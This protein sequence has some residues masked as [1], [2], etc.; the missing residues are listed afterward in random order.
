MTEPRARVD[1][2]EDK[3]NG[4]LRIST[5]VDVMMMR[6]AMVPA[7]QHALQDQARR[8]AYE[9]QGELERVVSDMMTDRMWVR[10]TLQLA[11]VEAV[12]T[13]MREEMDT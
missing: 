10:Q 11:M 6:K 9:M 5:E 13:M 1:L 7:I 8:L 3:M 2:T 12:S 4:V